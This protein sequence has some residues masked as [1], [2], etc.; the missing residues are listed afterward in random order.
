MALVRTTLS[1]AC[2]AGDTSLVVASATGFAAGYLVRVDQEVMRV[3]GNY[4]S[5]TTIPVIRGQQGTVVNAHVSGAGV[6][7]GIASDWASS[8]APQTVV[9]YP[10][11][12]RARTLT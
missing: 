7:A 12:G 4:T 2:A 1:S 11:A 8:Q 6:V 10:I 3:A 5:G 9:Q